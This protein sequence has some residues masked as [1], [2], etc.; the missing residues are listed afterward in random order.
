M[1]KPVKRRRR[2]RDGRGQRR[3][4]RRSANGETTMSDEHQKYVSHADIEKYV[5]D[6]PIDILA[7]L[8]NNTESRRAADHIDLA[9]KY[10]CE[11]RE[12]PADR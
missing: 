9:Y 3:S 11:S 7:R 2:R 6:L 12:R 1:K 10:A 5:K 4:E 8:P